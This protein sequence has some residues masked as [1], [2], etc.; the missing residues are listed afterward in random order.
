MNQWVDRSCREKGVSQ[1]MPPMIWQ[2]VGGRGGSTDKE[3]NDLFSPKLAHLSD[4]LTLDQ[5][6]IAVERLKVARS[7]NEVIGIY[8]DFD[9]DGTP[10]I[11]LLKRGLEGLG[12]Q[13]I[14]HYQPRRL[15]EGYGFHTW[16]VDQLKSKKVSLIITVDV[17]ITD[18]ETVKYAREQNIDVIVTDHHLPKKELPPALAIINPN[19]R[20]CPSGLSYLCGTGVAFYIVLA[21]KKSFKEWGKDSS[22]ELVKTKDSNKTGFNPKELLDCFAIGT[23]TDMVPLIKENRVLVKHGL[24]Q[25]ENTQ[26]PGLKALIEELGLGGRPLSSQEVVIRLAPKLNALSRMDTDLLPLD[27]FL[28]T[29]ASK[30]QSL[31]T[32]MMKINR[33]R[34]NLQ[35][36]A[37]KVA[38]AQVRERNQKGYVWVWSKDFHVGVIGLVATDLAEKLRVPAFVG[39]MN[40]K[41]RI[42]GSGRMPK[43]SSG[44]LLEAF[45]WAKENLVRFGGHNPAAGFELELEKTEDLN[46]MFSQFYN[47]QG[48]PNSTGDLTNLLESIRSADHSDKLTESPAHINMSTSHPEPASDSSGLVASSQTSL[49]F[50]AQGTLGELTHQFM[51]W[52]ESLEPF[53]VGFEIPIL[54]F[55]DVFLEQWHVLKGGHLKMWLR[56]RGDKVEAIWFFP[57]ANILE[58]NLQGKLVDILGQPQWNYFMRQKRLQLVIQDLRISS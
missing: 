4:P 35:K 16:G 31:V 2:I 46:Q 29:D 50:D 27:I 23:L 48:V 8:G 25:L 57:P 33:Q 14:C 19:K 52:Y 28:E 11:A 54:K 34:V 49:Y 55:S 56:E 41:G 42:V 40:E 5:M 9:L 12:F 7:N 30:A 26:R 38:E 44:S 17:G 39:A 3:V 51:K 36:M 15:K 53:G 45:E 13:H 58:K 24:I 21:L 22:E 20:T 32:K 43:E 37:Q 6:D 1:K 47:R 18:V 10:A